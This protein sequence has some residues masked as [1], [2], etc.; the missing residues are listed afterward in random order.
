MK[1]APEWNFQGS[2]RFVLTYR[3]GFK[4]F[5]MQ[6]G[7]YLEQVVRGSGDNVRIIALTVGDVR[8][9]PSGLIRPIHATRVCGL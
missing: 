7:T 6:A 1:D 5:V 9:I 3:A 4:V 2:R 8:F